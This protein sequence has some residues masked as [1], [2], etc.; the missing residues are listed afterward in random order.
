MGLGV[1]AAKLE[2]HPVTRRDLARDSRSGWTAP[3]LNELGGVLAGKG[4]AAFDIRFCRYS[5]YVD[6]RPIVGRQKLRAG[7]R[8]NEGTPIRGN[9][10]ADH[11]IS[12]G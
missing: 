7:W 9:V 2:V 8:G 10:H 3:C 12:T 5:A 11:C 4:W 1:Y 6:E